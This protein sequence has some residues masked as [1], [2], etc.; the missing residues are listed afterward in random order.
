MIKNSFLIATNRKY[1]THSKIVVDQ[2]ESYGALEDGEIIICCPFSIFDSFPSELNERVKYIEDSNQ[3][4][5]NVAFNEAAKH[6]VGEYIYILCDDHN[7]PP[8]IMSGDEFLNDDIFK[9]RKYKIGSMASQAT[10]YTGPVP[11]YPETNFMARYVTCRF[12]FM[13]RETYV[14]HLQEHIFHPY[15]TICSHYADCY[16]SY[17][18][19]INLEG[20]QECS[21]IQL[22]LMSN[23]DQK[24]ALVPVAQQ[25]GH[26]ESLAIHT[27][28]CEGLRIGDPYIDKV[29]L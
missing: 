23:T 13:N 27:K 12:P 5:G 9:D 4:N 15:F 1:T 26:D 14:K 22:R 20:A 16:L 28:L 7:V 10:C 17:F 24:D 25:F 2:L 3:Q 21:N 29:L 19:G 6:S 18:L 8:E 11:N